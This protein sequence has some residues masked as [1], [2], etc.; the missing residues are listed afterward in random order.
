MLLAAPCRFSQKFVAWESRAT[1]IIA[2]LGHWLLSPNSAGRSFV[3]SPTFTK[4][5]I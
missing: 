2:A 4:E 3:S 5:T 1:G